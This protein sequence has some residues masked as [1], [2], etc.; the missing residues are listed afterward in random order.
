ME[1]TQ[2]LKKIRYTLQTHEEN[3]THLI[4]RKRRKTTL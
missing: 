3:A 1:G 2:T 4:N